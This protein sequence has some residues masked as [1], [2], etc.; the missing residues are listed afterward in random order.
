MEFVINISD[1]SSET[2]DSE[3]PLSIGNSRI[4]EWSNCFEDFDYVALGHLHK[5]QK[6]KHDRIRYSGSILKYSK[7]EAIQKKTSLVGDVRRG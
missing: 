2:T 3:R 1:D 6:V 4:R 5:P 7:S